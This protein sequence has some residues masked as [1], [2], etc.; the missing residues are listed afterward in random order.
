M[1]LLQKEAATTSSV[2]SVGSGRRGLI[3]TERIL[4]I[5]M[6]HLTEFQVN[7]QQENRK[8]NDIGGNGEAAPNML[9]TLI[10]TS[11]I[12]GSIP[13][14]I[15][16]FLHKNTLVINDKVKVVDLTSQDIGSFNRRIGHA[17]EPKGVY[18]EA[19]QRVKIVEVG[20]GSQDQKEE[21][22]RRGGQLVSTLGVQR[23]RSL[24]TSDPAAAKTE[25]WVMP[26]WCHMFNSTLTGNVRV[27]FGDLPP[28]SI[29]NYDDLKKSFLENY[30]QQKK[31]IKYPIELHNIKQRDGESTKGEK[32]QLQIKKERRHS[33]HGNSMRVAKSKTSKKKV[34][35]T[36]KAPPPMTTPV[37]KRNHAKFCEFH[38][39]VGHNTN[40]CM[41][42]RKQI[43]EMLKAGKLSHL[44]KDIKQNN[45]KEQPKENEE[46]EGP[47]II[48]AEIGG[49]YVHRMYVDGESAS[50][51]M[52]EHCFSSHRLEIKKQLIPATTPLI[53]FSGEIIW[54]IEQ[55]QLLV[56]IGDEEHSALAWMNF[57]YKEITLKSS[58]LVPLECAMVFGPTKT[59]SATK[60]IAKERIKV[61]INMECP[62]QTP[63]D[64]TGVPRHIVEHRLNMPEGCPLIRQK[65]RGQAA[66]RNHAI[67]EEVGKLVEAGI[68]REVNYHDWLCNPVMV[69]KHD[70]SW[71]MCVDFKDLNKACP[72]D[73]EIV[74]DI[75]ETI[76]TLREINMKLNPKKCAFGVQEG[77]FLGYKVNA[78]GLKVCPDKLIAELP[79]LTAPMEKEELIV[80]LAATK[81]TMSR[82]V[83]TIG[84][85]MRIPLLYQ[86]EYSQWVERFMNYLEEQTDG[87]AMINSIK[88]DKSMWSDQEKKIQ[89]IDHLAR[90]LLIQGLANDIH[91]LIDSNKT[92]KDLWDALARHM[93]GSEYGKR[94]RKAVVLYEYETFKLLKEN[95]C[96]N[97]ETEQKLMDI[98]IDALYNILKQTQGYINDA[99][100]LK[101]KTVV[102]TSDPLALIA[103]KTKVSKRKEE[104]VVSLDSEGSDAGHFAKDCKKA[105]VKD[106][107]YYKTKMLLAKKYKDEQVLLAEDHA[108][109]ESSSDSDQE[110]NANMVFMAQIEKVLS[111]SE[112]ISS[113]SD[114][115]ISKVSYYLTEFEN[116]SEYET[117]EYY[118]NT[119]TYGLFVNDN[120]DQEIFHD[121]E[122]FPENLIESQI[123]HNESA[124]DYNDSEGINKLIRKFNR[125][126]AK[127]LNRIEK[128]NQQNK[129]FE[130]QKKDLQ[131]K[132]DVLKNQATTFKMKNKEFIKQL[133]V[134][135]KKNDDLLAQTNVLKDQLQVKHVVIDTL[136]RKQI[137][138]QEVLYDKMSVQL[139]ELDKHVRD[140]KNKVLE[141]DFKISELEECVRNKDLE[142][143]KCLERLND[144]EN[145]L[146][147]M[148]LTNQTV[149]M[150]MPSKDKMYN[151]RKGIGFENPSYFCKAK[152]L[153]P[154][155]YDERVINLGAFDCN[156][157]RNALCNARMNASVDVNDLFVFDDASIRKSHV[158]KMPFRKKPSASLNVPSRSKLNKSLPRIVRKW[159]PKLKPC[160]KHMTGNRAMLTNFVEKYLG[161]V[162]FGNNDFAVIDGYGDVVIGSMTIKKICYLLND[163]DDVGKLKAKGDIRVFARYSKESAAFRIYNK[164]TQTS[165][166]DLENLFQKFY[167]EYF[168]AS[169]IMKSSTMNVETSNVEIPLHEEEV[170]HERFESFQEESSSSFLNDDV[171][172]SLEEVVVPSSNIQSISN[173][174]VPNV[175][176]ASTSH[177][178]FNERLEDA[179]FD[180]STSFHDSSNVHTFYQPYPHEKKWTKDHP[181]HKIIGDPKS[182]VRTRGQLANS[183]L[184]SCLLSSIEPANVAEA[185]RDDDWDFT[186]FQMDVKTTFLNEILKEEVYVGQPPG[187]VN[188]QYPDHVYALNKA[189][190]GLKQA[191]RAWLNG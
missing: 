18:M 170:F 152:D 57:M 121:C 62:E 95:L 149:H 21:V 1:T 107:E 55:I 148:G 178:V 139:V 88:N 166:K 49:H 80:Y 71:R 120:D 27:W 31:Y 183:C 73:D 189:L 130:N 42:L 77:M 46:T 160:S 33:H 144:C 142:I 67:Q 90:S 91:S 124:V 151:G 182:S 98:N 45:G 162:R 171:H 2:K 29:D 123:D 164:R 83:L 78:K 185:L 23:N 32:W 52:Y 138:D 147:K 108:W 122:N 101:K 61:A 43:E 40:E 154:T 117:S 158:S 60:P 14:L 163:Y 184:F 136:H 19:P 155:L 82:D 146:H 35:G 69:K 93:L 81:E 8:D 156:N 38:G 64:T 16:Q 70:G 177:S 113:S 191:P 116:E 167:D 104:V 4:L 66:D 25:R 133:K 37:E 20:I 87:E 5:Q 135:I 94:D 106:Y 13:F 119:I 143:E 74:R 65:K 111:D 169:K 112:A 125:N 41:H 127:C 22:K 174:M 145:K 161:T 28:E 181:R 141:K 132:Y 103:E 173:N 129:D 79:M 137:A 48:M 187:F 3:L 44:M 15:H 126:I 54:L 59:P 85:T 105:K 92:T 96:N 179:Y 157:A 115:K 114:D 175:D 6:S 53:G 159:L 72:K 134:L 86:G 51:I 99:M 12:H 186:V 188:K 24:H 89:K 36:N 10:K 9:R 11:R 140:L 17:L 30:L 110:I 168:D 150:I 128:A 100:G 63:A 172:Q 165:K 190:Y 7:V 39:E 56:K 109:M 34:F 118:D 50:E 180:A 97:D 68:M 102:V 26:T 153:R 58:Q 47:M 84:S 76:K 75:E 176:E 131:D